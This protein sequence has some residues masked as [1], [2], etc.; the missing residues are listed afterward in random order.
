MAYVLIS[1]ARNEEAYIPKTLDSVIRQRVL[2][3]KWIIVSDG[4]TDGTDDIVAAYAARHDFIELVRVPGHADRNFASK[5]N[6]FNAGRERLHDVEY[7]FIG[8]LDAD[9]SFGPDYFEAI[10][11]KFLENPRLGVG[12]GTILE[13]EGGVFKGRAGNRE[14]SVAGAIQ[15]FRRECYEE[16]GGFIAMELGGE[17][18]VVEI[19][20]RMNGWEVRSFLD[21]EVFHHRPTGTQGLSVWRARFRQGIE[22]YVLGY[23]GIYF[24][25][26]CLGRLFEKPY[27]VGTALRI[28]GYCLSALKRRERPVS[29][30][31]L[32]F[33]KQEQR[34][35]LMAIAGMG[36]N[37]HS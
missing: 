4:S 36:K 7:D 32:E 10:I 16:T 8:N 17:D 5:V 11:G 23:D 21:L 15:F 3:K 6:A 14:R 28:L 27:V 37:R 24:L 9:V 12:G 20:A 19:S 22:D 29:P 31:F 2:P 34:K 26:K 33:P 18:S 13:S 35:R 30:R 25:G 1:T